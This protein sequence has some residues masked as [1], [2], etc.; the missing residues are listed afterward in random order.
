[1]PGRAGVPSRHIIT[2]NHIPVILPLRRKHF[3]QVTGKFVTSP[4]V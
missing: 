1:L 4:S 3:R 2:Q